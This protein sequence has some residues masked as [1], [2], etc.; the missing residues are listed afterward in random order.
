MEG[1]ERPEGPPS[2]STMTHERKKQHEEGRRATTENPLE[3]PEVTT[4]EAGGSIIKALNIAVSLFSLAA[5]HHSVTN[6]SRRDVPH[7]N[8]A[9]PSVCG[10]KAEETLKDPGRSAQLLPTQ[11]TQ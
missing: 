8:A 2:R 9:S 7:P 10:Q 5:K 4:G 11:R 1:E 6:Y 3:G